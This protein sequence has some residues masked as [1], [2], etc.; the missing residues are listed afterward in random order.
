MS[1]LRYYHQKPDFLYYSGV[2]QQVYSG[3]FYDVIINLKSG[4]SKSLKCRRAGRL[5]KPRKF[6]RVMKNDEVVV[7]L[8]LYDLTNGKIVL[9]RYKS[10]WGNKK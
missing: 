9:C 2:V 4:A 7:E 8:S 3:N 10:G 6:V 1:I 5:M